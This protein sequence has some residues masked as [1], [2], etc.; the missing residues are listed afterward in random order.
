MSKEKWIDEILQSAGNIQPIEGDP[1][2]ATKVEARLNNMNDE[3]VNTKIP[4]RWLFVNIA[5]MLLLLVMNI[6][7]WKGS[8]KVP[9][10][11]AV[12]QLIH[13]YGFSQNDIYSFNYSN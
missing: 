8:V 10:T 4:L 6:A 7:I 3:A 13:D 5:A 2:L 11:N 9:K 12:Q 1:W